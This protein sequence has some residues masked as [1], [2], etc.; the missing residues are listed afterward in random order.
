[1]A[2]RTRRA[3]F[4]SFP[5]AKD[6]FE[7]LEL[8]GDLLY[9]DNP[10][11][12]VRVEAVWIDAKS[13]LAKRLE[14]DVTKELGWVIDRPRDGFRPYA[15]LESAVRDKTLARSDYYV[16]H[17]GNTIGSGRSIVKAGYQIK[18]IGR[19]VQSPWQESLT[20]A[21]G[22]MF[23]RATVHDIGKALVLEQWS[24]IPT[25]RAHTCLLVPSGALGTGT[26]EPDSFLVARPGSPVRVSHLQWVLAF[27]QRLFLHNR[28]SRFRR[29]ANVL[30]GRAPDAS[31]D[32]A[33]A[34]TLFGRIF[35][36]AMTGLVEARLLS[37]CLAN[38]PDNGDV[39]ARQFDFEDILFW[40]PRARARVKRP[41]PDE[42][43]PPEEYLLRHRFIEGSDRDPYWGSLQFLQNAFMCVHALAD[44]IGFD[45]GMATAP[46]DRKGLE[47]LYQAEIGTFLERILRSAKGT[48]EVGRAARSL[49]SA[50]PLLPGS[51]QTTSFRAVLEAFVARASGAAEKDD[52]PAR[53]IGRTLHRAL[54]RAPTAKSTA[55]HTAIARWLL[56]CDGDHIQDHLHRLILET[57]AITRE[58]SF[59]KRLKLY[60]ALFAELDRSAAA[61][62]P[63]ASIRG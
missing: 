26:D 2:S 42:D 53:A 27:S 1:M 44:G 45:R 38:W 51:D 49:S 58:E 8:F 59:A 14:R 62:G 5:S 6:S 17:G 12:P 50:T 54:G 19:T 7:A 3:S 16:C 28:L 21:D 60:R 57:P 36:H 31:F 33:T 56:E 23:A 30:L 32:A 13:P 35:Q 41:T 10:V 48:A 39:Y 52:E 4:D 15:E 24:R 25:I 9:A 43:E 34:T 20:D 61:L 29:F 63:T 55:R 37:I 22:R 18:G 46:F 47:R 40:F 11:V